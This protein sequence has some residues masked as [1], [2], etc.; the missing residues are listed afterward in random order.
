MKTVLR[1]GLL[2]SALLMNAC[3]KY[4]RAP[5]SEIKYIPAGFI[6]PHV[7]GAFHIPV[8]ARPIEV[9]GKVQAVWIDQN[10]QSIHFDVRTGPIHRLMDNVTEYSAGDTAWFEIPAQ[11]CPQK[12]EVYRTSNAV[13][14]TIVSLIYPNSVD[15]GLLAK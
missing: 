13:P 4:C 9:Y 12:G 3:E 8:L 1:A 15:N 10:A 6:G 2:G 5:D 14:D 11:S 7:V